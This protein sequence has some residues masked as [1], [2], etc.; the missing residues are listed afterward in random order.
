MLNQTAS[1]N[2]AGQ[3]PQG[4]PGTPAEFVAQTFEEARGAHEGTTQII[5]LLT[6]GEG[7]ADP[8]ATVIDMMEIMNGKVDLILRH[9]GVAEG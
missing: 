2:G 1:A 5:D 3:K 8:L 4:Q 6:A 9:L 7:Q